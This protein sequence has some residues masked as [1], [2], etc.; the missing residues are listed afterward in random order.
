MQDR[1]RHPTLNGDRQRL[2]LLCALTVAVMLVSGCGSSSAG[3]ATDALGRQR[4]GGEYGGRHAS[5]DTPAGADFARWVL[6]QDRRREY[7]TDAVVRGD[8]ALGV[9]VQPS[10]RRNELQ[11]LVP[12]LA[13]R[14]S[15]QFPGRPLEVLAFDQSGNRLARGEYNPRTGRVDLRLE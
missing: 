15:Q 4:H 9:K 3:A 1:L 7:I 2:A 14:M 8:R 6:D 13:E 10:M 11:R 5:G 12:A